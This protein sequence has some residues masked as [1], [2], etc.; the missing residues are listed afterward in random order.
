MHKT[1]ER[2]DSQKKHEKDEKSL[3]LAFLLRWEREE[4]IKNLCR[5]H[6]NYFFMQSSSSSSIYMMMRATRI[7]LLIF[8]H[9]S[10]VSAALSTCW[11]RTEMSHSFTSFQN[12][13]ARS[14]PLIHNSNIF[15]LSLSNDDVRTTTWCLAAVCAVLYWNWNFR[16]NTVFMWAVISA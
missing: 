6:F 7:I 14:S 8:I 4:K 5:I 2:R 15:F 1:Y 9:V 10:S 3:N 13:L 12:S 16:S 11:Y